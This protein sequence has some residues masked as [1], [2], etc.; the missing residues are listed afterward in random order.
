M[1]VQQTNPAHH[2][3]PGPA[4]GASLA[5]PV[6]QKLRPIH[7]HADGQIVLLQKLAPR[8][9]QQCRIRLKRVPDVN[10]VFVF[11]TQDMQRLFVETNRQH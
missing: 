9:C 2:L 5:V 4:P 1:V 8:R 10:P 7:A 11:L 6:V 3:L